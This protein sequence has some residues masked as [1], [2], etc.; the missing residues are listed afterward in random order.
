LALIQPSQIVA[1][2]H[3]DVNAVCRVGQ[4]CQNKDCSDQLSVN[5]TSFTSFTPASFSLVSSH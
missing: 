3:E 2:F 4:K 5:K 1:N